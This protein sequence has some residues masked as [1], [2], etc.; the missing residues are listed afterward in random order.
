MSNGDV[1]LRFILGV[2]GFALCIVCLG[3]LGAWIDR[4]LGDRK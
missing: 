1:I 3:F 2:V 4:K